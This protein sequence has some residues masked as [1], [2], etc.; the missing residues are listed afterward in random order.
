[1]TSE[2]PH[3][4]ISCSQEKRQPQKSDNAS[5]NIP[6]AVLW[7]PSLYCIWAITQVVFIQLG[8]K[9]D[10]MMWR[11]AWQ[12]GLLP[13]IKVRCGRYKWTLQQ[14]GAPCHTA[15]NTESCS[16]RTWSSPSK[17][18]CPL[19]SLDSN[20]VNLPSGCSSADGL[21][22]SKFLLSWQNEDGDCQSMTETTAWRSG[23]STKVSVNGEMSS[24]GIGR[25]QCNRMVD[26]LNIC[27][28]QKM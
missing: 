28:I 7:C 12:M 26:L 16:M 3:L 5:A 27:S 11:G 14:D 24:F 1:M 2:W 15:R 23:S 21:P 4:L 17:T 9:L 8:G 22:S 20:S 10:T 19:N 25:V 13:D 6:A 18:F